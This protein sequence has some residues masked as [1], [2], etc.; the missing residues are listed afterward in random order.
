MRIRVLQA[1]VFCLLSSGVAISG[2]TTLGPDVVPFVVFAAHSIALRHVNLIDGT[3]APPRANQTVVI[4]N[5]RIAAIVPAATPPPKGAEV[6]DYPGYSVLPGLVGMHDHLFYSSSNA[7]QRGSGKI[8]EPGSLFT[9]IA[10][11]A[12]RLYLAAGVTTL[13]TTGSIEPYADLKVRSRI[14]AGL[15]PGPHLDLTGPYLEGPM[16]L[17][18]QMHELASPH[19]A[20]EFVGFWAESGMTSF[21]ASKS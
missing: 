4:I 17:F 18:A 12:P 13:R 8:L 3:G 6:H 1:L 19:E 11:T 15:M 2:A 16:S 10:Y 7:L 5:G 9:E 21:K 20:H 14:E